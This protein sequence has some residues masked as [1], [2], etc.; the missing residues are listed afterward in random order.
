MK[1]KHKRGGLFLP[2]KVSIGTRIKGYKIG[3]EQ[4]SALTIGEV[5]LQPVFSK[6]K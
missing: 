2:P 1:G 6:H 3:H 5:V 4:V